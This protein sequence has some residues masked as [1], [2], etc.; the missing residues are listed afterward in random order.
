MPRGCSAGF[1]GVGGGLLAGAFLAGAFLA[2]A[3]FAAAF[4][5][6]AFLAGAF[7]GFLTALAG[8]FFSGGIGAPSGGACGAVM[9][10]LLRS[11]QTV[12]PP[13]RG[14]PGAQPGRRRGGASATG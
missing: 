3:F 11:S 8:G 13:A 4:F 14:I 9:R 1:G 12:F 2:A 7:A 6:G 10:P 5:A